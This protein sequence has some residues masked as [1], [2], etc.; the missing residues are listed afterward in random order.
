MSVIVLWWAWCGGWVGGLMFAGLGFPDTGS[1]IDRDLN[2]RT[3]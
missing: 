1:E 3:S 2:R